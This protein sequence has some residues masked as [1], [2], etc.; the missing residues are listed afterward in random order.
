MQTNRKVN[1]RSFTIKNKPI[2]LYPGEKRQ[3]KT[4]EETSKVEYSAKN[5]K[6]NKPPLYSVL[7]PDTNSDSL[8]EKS[9]GARWDSASKQKTHTGI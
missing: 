7:K 9:K 5:T 8:S 1:K 6:A 3:I 2:N 4:T